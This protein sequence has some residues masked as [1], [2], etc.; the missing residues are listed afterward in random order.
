MKVCS[1][2]GAG[3]YY[4]PGTDIC[5]KIGGYV[6]TEWSYGSGADATAG[7]WGG[8]HGYNTRL[9]SS[10]AS[11]ATGTTITNNAADTT[12]R[13]RAYINYDARQQTAYG[14]LRTYFQVG[15]SGNNNVIFSANR[16][17]VQIAGF[18]VGLASSYFDFYSV[19][20]IA[21]IV[22]SSSDTGDGGQQVFAYTAQLGNGLS[23]T[24]SL[25]QPNAKRRTLFHRGIGLSPVLGAATGN[26]Y[27]KLVV[28]EVVGNIRIAQ[29]WGSAQVMG[30][31]HQVTS[32]YYIPS[33]TGS[34]NGQNSGHASDKWGWA[35]GAGLR[36]NTPMIAPGNYFSTQ[37]AYSQGATRY[38]YNTA[39]NN[40]IA[41]KGGQ[42]LGYGITTDGVVGLTGE[43]DLTTSWGVAGGY[44]HF[45]TPSLR[46]SVHGSY[47]ELKY[48]TNANTNICALQVGAAGAAG[49]LSFDAAGASGTATC[50]NNWSTWQIGSR[51]QW[52][53][54][55]DFYMGFDVVYQKL[56]SASRGATAHFGAAGAQP[57]G[58]RTIEDQDVIHTRVR[59]HRDIAP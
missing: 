57:S 34:S 38:V 8:N 21:Y 9:D 41:M 35:V 13:T 56:R 33:A 36:V 51:T 45:W 42:S 6:R 23:A 58:L 55:R 24:L 11:A 7:P 43:I 12:W 29:A 19:A 59:W 14:T 32:S 22:D 30:A 16:A 10:S 48:N 27:A 26:G 53:V 4:I 37:V 2:Y 39:P 15:L 25:E 47:V 31:L 17:F 1:L 54:T 46:T 18:T 44:E 40:P 49:G 50:N 20:A 3:Y 5:M 52:N 28:P